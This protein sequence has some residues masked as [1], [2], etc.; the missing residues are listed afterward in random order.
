[1]GLDESAF[2]KLDKLALDKISVKQIESALKIASIKDTKKLKELLKFKTLHDGC[3]EA[4]QFLDGID[5]SE[6]D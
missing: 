6:L 5:Y 3:I 1:M 2:E 4:I